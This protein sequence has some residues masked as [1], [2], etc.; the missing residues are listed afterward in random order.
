MIP[1]KSFQPVVII[2]APRSGTNMLRDVLSRIPRIGTW[3]CDEI[4]Y[5]WR[6][7]NIRH[8]SD[9]FSVELARPEVV[10]YIRNQFNNFSSGRSLDYVLEKTCANSL[11]ISFVDRVLPEAKYIFIVRDGRDVVAS[12]MN[13]WK[14]ELNLNYIL[15]KARYVPISDFAYYASRYF[16]NRVYRLISK[17][18]RLS[19]WGPS[20]HDMASIQTR[21]SLAEVC[22]IQWSECVKQSDIGFKKISNDRVH[23]I[24]YENF[25]TNPEKE[26]KRI[27]GFLGIDLPGN[28]LTQ[29]IGH[30][31]SKS[32]G[33]GADELGTQLNNIMPLMEE[34]L[35]HHGYL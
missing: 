13:R 7:G 14:A 33:K 22:A 9:V 6:H 5:I 25:V 27:S 1:F 16:T 18:Q 23:K 21:H 3:P 2:G 17:E 34:M 30:V 24:T 12:A 28:E 20:L 19:S 4:N 10:K 11:R 29:I 26:L 8:P 32:I 31:S 15:A 35:Q